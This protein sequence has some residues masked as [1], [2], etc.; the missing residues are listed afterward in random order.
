MSTRYAWPSGRLVAAVVVI[1]LT[2]PMV[3]WAAAAQPDDLELSGA[4]LRQAIAVQ[5]WRGDDGVSAYAQVGEARPS[6]DVAPG[7]LLVTMQN[8]QPGPQAFAAAGYDA[9][10]EIATGVVKVDVDPAQVDAVV[11]QLLDRPDVAAV[12]P[13]RIRRFHAVPD[14]PFYPQQWAHRLT[15]MESAWDVTTGDT[16]VVV[17]IVDSGIVSSHPDLANITQQVQSSTGVIRPGATDNDTCKLGHGTRVAGVLAGVGN[18]ANGVTG[19]NWNVSILDINAADPAVTCAGP[20][21]AG[22][23]AA[24]NHASTQGA[25]VI[26]LSLGGAAARCPTSM[27]TTIDNAISAGAIVVASAGNGGSGGPQVPGSCNGV[28]SVGAV[29]SSG[30][31]T[32]YSA[33][34]PYVDV[35]APGGGG[36]SD[37]AQNDVLTTS[38]YSAGERSAEYVTSGG[39]SYAAPYVSGLAALIL[40]VRPE[41]NPSQVESLLE[42]TAT[43]LGPAGRDDASGWG[44]VQGASVTLAGVGEDVVAAQTD[45]VFPVGGT[46][47]TRPGGEVSTFRLA[48]GTRT[49]EPISQAVAASRAV[50]ADNGLTTQTRPTNAKWAVIARDDDYADGLTGSSLTLGVA[51]L[52]F[53]KKTGALASAT[54]GELTRVLAAGSTVYLLG[55]SAAL[56]GTLDAEVKALGFKPVRL[57]GPVREATAVKVADEVDRLLVQTLKLAPSPVVILV[58]RGDWPDAVAAGALGARF[59]YPIL[60]TPPNTLAKETAAALSKRNVEDLVIVGGTVKVSDATAFRALTLARVDST[61]RL[62]GTERNGTVVAVSAAV[63]DILASTPSVRPAWAVAVNV[64]RDD[65]YAHMVSSTVPLAVMNGVFVPVGDGNTPIAPVAQTYATGLG[66]PPLLVGKEDVITAETGALLERIV[67]TAP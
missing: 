42:S 30:T 46:N 51:P 20:T 19:V 50:F 21:D 67:E 37:G 44:L 39:T 62:A 58:N 59:G 54:A 18:N 28:I 13:N 23:I 1:V 17:A 33:T 3:P 38:Y 60:L 32:N 55:G 16:D 5:Q 14:D 41:L 53:T 22:L 34:N 56:P 7:S 65:A 35:V 27:Q 40:A 26:N 36:G 24:I 47:R 2:L 49:T 15:F 64:S 52:L 57:A 11:Q 25:D 43:D 6:E 29:T 4:A 10:T 63:E 12:E 66:V 45:P 31:V 9:V 61:T 48:S 8:G